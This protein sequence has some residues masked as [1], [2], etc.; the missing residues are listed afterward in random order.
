[1]DKKSLSFWLSLC[2]APRVGIKKISQLLNHYSVEELQS[3]QF[4]DWLAHK[5]Q[6]HQAKFI[7]ASSHKEVEYCLE[8]QERVSDHAIVTY[9]DDDYPYLLKEIASPPPVMFVQGDTSVLAKPQ[10]AVVGSRHASHSGQQNAFSFSRN[11][12]EKQFVVTSGLALGV[13]GHAHDGALKAGGETIAVLGCGF[14]HLYPKSHRN[15]AQRVREQ[16]ALV[17]EFLPDIKPRAEFFPRRNRII[18]GLSLGTLVVEAAE[19]S[20]SLIT[21][22]YAVEQNR[23]V[24]VIPGSIHMANSRGSNELIRAGA[25]LVQNTQ[26]I[27]DEIKHLVTCGDNPDRITNEAAASASINVQEQLPFSQLLANVGEEAT[28]VD[29]IAS[30]THIPV[31]EVTIQLLELELKGLVVAVSGGYIRNGRG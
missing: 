14:E 21:A 11:L 9:L 13:D 18:S 27:L 7:M 28:P 25:C 19:K 5:F 24:F 15:L 8:W 12:S 26:Q 17:S 10:I 30:R 4:N 29:I 22:K 20:G 1:M 2:L 16:G 6:P 3:F 31:H 23:E